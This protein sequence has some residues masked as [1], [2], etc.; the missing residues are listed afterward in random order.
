MHRLIGAYFTL[1][2]DFLPIEL[3]NQ[4]NE[5]RVRSEHADKDALRRMERAA[6][7][8][9]ITNPWMP[10]YAGVTLAVDV[11]TAVSS[12]PT[13]PI[14]IASAISSSPSAF[15]RMRQKV[16]STTAMTT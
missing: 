11:P 6:R 2:E 3:L 14:A 13:L 7:I 15:S 5:L 8:T 1:F 12:A 16:S 4:L 9:P 10:K